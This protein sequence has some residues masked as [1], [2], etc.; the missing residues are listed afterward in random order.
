MAALHTHACARPLSAASICQRAGSPPAVPTLR[1]SWEIKYRKP[2]RESEHPRIPFSPLLPASC[3]LSRRKRRAPGA[4]P[5]PSP[6]SGPPCSPQTA[7]VLQPP[8]GSPPPVGSPRAPHTLP[9]ASRGTRQPW[10]AP[11]QDHPAPGPGAPSE[12]G[13]RHPGLGGLWTKARFFPGSC[14]VQQIQTFSVFLKR[15]VLLFLHPL[16][17][18]L[19]AEASAFPG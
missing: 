14:P 9:C 6:P 17:F 10:G 12:P 3:S 19:F 1:P 15:S 13:S 8:L 11:C 5:A 7:C 18:P 4:G 2:Q 16:Y